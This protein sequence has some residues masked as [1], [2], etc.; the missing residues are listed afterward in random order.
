MHAVIDRQSLYRY[1]NIKQLF[2]NAI[3]HLDNTFM[4]YDLLTGYSW[5]LFT[6]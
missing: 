3:F 4:P 6:T 1:P 2:L 5:M